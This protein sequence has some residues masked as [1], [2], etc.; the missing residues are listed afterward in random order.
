VIGS[1]RQA[2]DDPVSYWINLIEQNP[3][4]PRPLTLFILDLCYS[5]AAAV[6]PWHQEMATEK[7]R[8]WVI[9]ASGRESLAFDYRLSRATVTVL[10]HYHDGSLR[11]DPSSRYIPLGDIA[12]EIKREVTVLS[13]GVT[14]RA[15][16]LAAFRSAKSRGI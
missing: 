15:L 2:F 13:S 12:Q 4:K 10:N 7:R 14:R 11:V 1:D 5:G 9:A 8:A 16:R 6:L 3:G